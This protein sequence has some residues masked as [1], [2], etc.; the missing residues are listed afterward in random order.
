MMFL[1][2]AY[3]DCLRNYIKAQYKNVLRWAWFQKGEE[4]REEAPKTLNII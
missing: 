2:A 1:A 4:S 3:I